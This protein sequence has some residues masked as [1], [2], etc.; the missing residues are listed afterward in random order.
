M[1]DP[2]P[3]PAGIMTTIPEDNWDMLD[4]GSPAALT[5]GFAIAMA[6]YGVTYLSLVRLLAEDISDGLSLSREERP[7]AEG[8]ADR[9]KRPRYPPRI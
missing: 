1:I 7:I 4:D 6:L 2:R 9:R 5:I 8:R 3:S